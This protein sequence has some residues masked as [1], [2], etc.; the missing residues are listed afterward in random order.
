MLQ[1]EQNT[2]AALFQLIHAIGSWWI[3]ASFNALC[4]FQLF[5]CF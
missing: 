2:I 3:S 5:F 1:C 4:L